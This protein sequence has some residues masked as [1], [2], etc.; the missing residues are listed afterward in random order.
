MNDLFMTNLDSSR[1]GSKD[2]R[3]AGHVRIVNFREPWRVAFKAS[4]I[5]SAGLWRISVSILVIWR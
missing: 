5:R 3:C 2:R 1:N 4:G